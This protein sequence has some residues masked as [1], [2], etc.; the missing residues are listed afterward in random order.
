LKEPQSSAAARQAGWPAIL[1]NLRSPLEIG[2]ALAIP[3][4]ALGIESF[5]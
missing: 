1:S 4:V 2:A 5:E 3:P